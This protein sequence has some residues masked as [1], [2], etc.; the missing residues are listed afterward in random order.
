MTFNGFS[1]TLELKVMK[2]IYKQRVAMDQ[3]QQKNI[4]TGSTKT[5]QVILHHTY[6][7]HLLKVC[8]GEFLFYAPK[9]VLYISP[10]WIIR[11]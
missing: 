10:L 11:C 9:S 4:E 7:V 5:F 6:F 2:A 3:L 1:E 8:I